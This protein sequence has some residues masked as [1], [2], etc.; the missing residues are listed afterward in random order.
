[1]TEKTVVNITM[2]GLYFLPKH[3]MHNIMTLN[4]FGI[5]YSP[6]VSSVHM[7]VVL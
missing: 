3:T 2:C 1:M 5:V 4:I 6:H 7:S